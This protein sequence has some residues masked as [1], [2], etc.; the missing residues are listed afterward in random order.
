MRKMK[1]TFTFSIISVYET[2]KY[3]GLLTSIWPIFSKNRYLW[4][5]MKAVYYFILVNYLCVFIP[6]ILMTLFNINT[7]ATVTITAVE[8]MIIVEAVYNLLYTR[9]YSA[10][11]KSAVKEIEEFFKNSSPKER[12]ILDRY[13]T[14]RTFFNIYIAIN[15]FVA[16]MSFNFGQ[17]FLKDRPY[18]LNLWYPFTIKSQVIVVIIYIHQV[19]V[20]THTLI[21]IVFDLIVQIFLWTLA[22]RF[23]LLQADFKKTA[24]E[25]DLKCNIQKHQYLIRTTEAVIDF[26]KYMILK[27]FLAV[28]ILV[29]SSTLQ[30]LHRGPSTIIVQ[31]FFIMK[32]ASMR[33]FAYC[34]AGHSLA[35]KTGGL[36]R[37]IY[38]SYWINQT[39]RMKTNVLIV[40]QRC[41]KPTVVKISGI[42]SSLS[43]R[44]CVNYFYMIYSAFMTLRAVLEV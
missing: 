1:C 19:I 36:A 24:S 16:I 30:I 29:I 21:L 9:F 2:L 43:F 33:A 15:Y 37:S 35:E 27:V 40:M 32:I 6:L 23:E 12:Y 17:L 42:I 5:F 3:F 26:T 8:Q 13:A 39:Q 18:P 10:Q 20:I 11:F 4:V 34:W 28:T 22:A 31:F 41:Q 44:F 7:S 25:M 38:N 14:T